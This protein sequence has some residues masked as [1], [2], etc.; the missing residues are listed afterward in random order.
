MIKARKI[1]FQ[2][3]WDSSVVFLVDEELEREL[4]AE[5]E[6][7][8]ETA[9]DQRV[10]EAADINVADIADFLSQKNNALDV[11]LRGIGLSE[12][13]F[14][15][16]VSLLQKLRRIPGD[17]DGEWSMR[18]VKSK[19][20]CEPD[21]AHLMAEV[22]VDGKRDRELKQHVPRHYLDMLNY[23][24]IKGI[25]QAARRIRYKESLIGSYEDRKK[26]K[27]DGRIRAQL[28]EIKAKH[29]LTYTRVHPMF[30]KTNIGLFAVPSFEDAWV[31]IVG[32][33]Q[34]TTSIDQ[35]TKEDYMMSAYERVSRV[36]RRN[37]ENR[38]FVNFVDGGGWLARKRDLERLV[39]H[40]HYFINLQHLDMV[41]AIVL[42]HVPE[43][44]FT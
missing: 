8:L 25:S 4:K 11:I 22:L 1:S 19:L 2:E 17:L 26:Q 9:R 41:E 44:Y 16:I 14:K 13:K 12:E 33:F 7:L 23:R 6:A 3:A 34:E 31:V 29:G 20:A 32:S 30:V 43:R 37:S 35:I 27:V 39:V 42:Q 36:N 38:A 24:E 15:C 5:V 18:E 28:E 10:S 40:C 21:F